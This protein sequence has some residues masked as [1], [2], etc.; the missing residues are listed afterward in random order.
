MLLFKFLYTHRR[1]PI[2][3]RAPTEIPRACSSSKRHT[4]QNCFNGKQRDSVRIRATKLYILNSKCHKMYSPDFRLS[5]IYFSD[6]PER[7]L[8]NTIKTSLARPFRML[9]T[10]IIIQVLAVYMAYIYG[11]L[12][13]VLSTF[14]V[15]WATRYKEVKALHLRYLAVGKA[16]SIIFQSIGI[17]SLNYISIALGLTVGTQVLSINDRIYCTLKKR[18]NGVGKPEFRVPLMVV[19][20]LLVP[21]GLFWYGWNAQAQTHWIMPNIGAAIFA[22]G[23]IMGF[24]GIQTYLV[25]AYTRYAASATAAGTVLRSLAGFGFPLFAPAIYNA[26][27]RSGV[28][29]QDGKD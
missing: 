9:G 18:N 3:Y 24:Q 15:L 20:S 7:T 23:S 29:G 8:T 25:D 19:G 6:H 14:H 17:G 11:L 21:I 4:H 2:S 27:G 13:L 5:L 28:L 16:L 1:C 22:A 26:L 10:Q 12:Y